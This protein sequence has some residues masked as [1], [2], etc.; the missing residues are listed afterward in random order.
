MFPLLWK[1]IGLGNIGIGLIN[2]VI[3]VIS[4]FILVKQYNIAYRTVLVFVPVGLV[5]FFMVPHTESFF[6]LGT[7]LIIIGFNEYNYWLIT[8]GAIIAIG[9]R[10]ASMIFLV[11][12]V[13]MLLIN[14]V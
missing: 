14:F 1:A 6:F 2:F 5:W 10:S 11:W 12:F 7:V 9:T 13:M 4:A 8:L 3:F